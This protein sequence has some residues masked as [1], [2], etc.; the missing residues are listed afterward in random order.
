[1]SAS[2]RSVVAGD[3]ADFRNFV[4]MIL[5]VD[6]PKRELGARKALLYAVV[7][8][9]ENHDPDTGRFTSGDGGGG[10]SVESGSLSGV[11]TQSFA[12][13]LVGQLEDMEAAL[14]SAPKVEAI[15]QAL[16]APPI[17]SEND[18]PKGAV[19]WVNG[20]GPDIDEKELG[21]IE[22]KIRARGH[23]A[24][25]II[26]K[27]GKAL[28]ASVGTEGSAPISPLIISGMLDATGGK[29]THNHPNA[30]SLSGPDVVVA[31]EMGLR[32]MRA[33]SDMDG[34]KVDNWLIN[35]GDRKLTEHESNMVH[36]YYTQA[37]HRIFN[38]QRINK[39][40]EMVGIGATDKPLTEGFA[41]IEK[42]PKGSEADKIATR[43]FYEDSHRIM[44]EF[45]KLANSD[46]DLKLK[47]RYGRKVH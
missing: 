43:I 10:G 38:Q 13:T 20:G 2:D 47:L 12:N 32:E 22:D 31:L 14:E 40:R 25:V 45:V 8:Y 16:D 41:G 18:A 19:A 28:T 3:N 35:E 5:G 34:Q 42:I 15:Y 33:V 24:A 9:N 30:S 27:D 29:M 21:S 1:M 17:Q 11:R 4:A 44:N 23:E 26:G 46:S 37:K 39:I 7:K 36:S 6:L